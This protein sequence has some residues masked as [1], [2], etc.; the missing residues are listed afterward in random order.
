MWLINQPSNPSARSKQQLEQLVCRS[1]NKP[2]RTH[3]F[4]AHAVDPSD[5]R[6]KRLR[7]RRSCHVGKPSSCQQAAGTRPCMPLPLQPL[8]PDRCASALALASA[9]CPFAP[10]PLSLPMPLLLYSPA[11]APVP[12]MPIPEVHAPIRD[13]VSFAGITHAILAVILLRRALG[14]LGVLRGTK[15]CV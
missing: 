12:F 3:A 5:T 11:P 9:P 1:G 13:S 7:T 6:P 8:P 15:G 4:Q 10:C 2:V 14:V